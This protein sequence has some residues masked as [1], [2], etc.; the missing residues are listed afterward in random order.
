MSTDGQNVVALATTLEETTVSLEESKKIIEQLQ[1]DNK[2]LASEICMLKSPAAMMVGDDNQI[3]FY[4]GLPSY[5]IF[6][7]LLKLFSR[8]IPTASTGCGLG[9]SD[10]LL[11]VLMKLRLAVP[12]QDLGYCFRIL[13]IV[14]KFS[15]TDRHQFQLTQK[16]TQIMSHNYTVKFLIAISPTGATICVKVLGWP[17]V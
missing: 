17:S 4:T 16:L 2:S 15:L 10:Q 3:R 6:E 7:T 11:L 13:K 9:C 12:N 1:N 14:Q 8:V 5:A